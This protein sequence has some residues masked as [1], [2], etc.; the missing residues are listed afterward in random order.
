ML[1]VI[2]VKKN[3]ISKIFG[4]KFYLMT[5]NRHKLGIAL[6]VRDEWESEFTENWFHK[7]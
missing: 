7:E 5:D 2:K 3:Q 1:N 4:A 6:M